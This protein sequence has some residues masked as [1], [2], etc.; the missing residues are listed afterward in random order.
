MGPAWPC[1]ER[2]SV[3]PQSAW[4]C[5]ADVTP[6]HAL[7]CACVSCPRPLSGLGATGRCSPCSGAEPVLQQLCKLKCSDCG[8]LMS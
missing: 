6:G 7:L 3:S 5:W 1:P 4:N 2:L 8:V